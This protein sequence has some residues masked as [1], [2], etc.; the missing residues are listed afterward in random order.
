MQVALIADTHLS[1]RAPECVRNWHAAALAVQ[2]A[3]ADLTIHLGDITLDG[4]HQPDEIL[5]AAALTNAWPTRLRCVIGNHDMGTGSGEQPLRRE[6]LTR[7][8][9]A[10][11][12]DCWSLN[13]DDWTLIGVNAQLFGSGGPEERVQRLWIEEVAHN[14]SGDKVALFTHRPIQRPAPNDAMPT[15]RYVER[16]RARWLLDG[17][18]RHALRLVVSGHTHQALD[19][20]ANGVRHVWVPSAS[21]VIADALQKPV[22]QKVVGIGRLTLLPDACEYTLFTPPGVDPHELTATSFYKEL[23]A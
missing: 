23:V 11:G 10:F 15:G 4:E 5:F 6:A 22:G 9:S 12:P 20:C 1:A 13:A 16:E 17:P 14:L 2:A 3:P 18:L 19:F 21:F 7:C 8:I